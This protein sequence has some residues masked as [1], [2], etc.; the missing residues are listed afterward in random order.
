MD[1]DINREPVGPSKSPQI[2]P[3]LG[4]RGLLLR[5]TWGLR[6]GGDK[7]GFVRGT[8]Q[9]VRVPGADVSFATHEPVP[10]A[11]TSLCLPLFFYEMRVLKHLLRAVVE[12]FTYKHRLVPGMSQA[13][14][15]CWL[16]L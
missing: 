1:K 4:G 12:I 8:A 13:I 11:Q 5:R 14:L 16:L 2:T 7:S 3:V 10:E 15:K 6:M 9:R